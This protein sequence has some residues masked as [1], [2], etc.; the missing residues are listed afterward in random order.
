M[1]IDADEDDDV[2]VKA[3]NTIKEN[4]DPD[5]PITTKQKTSNA[6]KLLLAMGGSA[7]LSTETTNNSVTLTHPNKTKR[8]NTHHSASNSTDPTILPQKGE[9]IK[10]TGQNNDNK[11]FKPVIP[12]PEACHLQEMKLHGRGAPTKVVFFDENERQCGK[13]Q[14]IDGKMPIASRNKAEKYPLF[15]IKQTSTTNKKLE[16]KMNTM[17]ET[18][19]KRDKFN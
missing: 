18:I 2:T 7:N 8:L 1:G 15:K 14:N 16:K 6:S 19:R 4:E 3:N 9:T 10:K 17:T 5:Q 11:Q 13:S 12:L